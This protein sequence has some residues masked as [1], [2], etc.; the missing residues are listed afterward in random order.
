MAALTQTCKIALP[1]RSAARTTRASRR[2]AIVAKAAAPVDV[3]RVQQ[4]AVAS[5]L[6]VGAVYE[7]M[8][9]PAAQAAMEL[10][11]V[12]EGEPF[13]VNLAWAAIMAT[14]SFSLSLV[15]WGRSGL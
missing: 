2:C 10:T 11:Q 1:A 15:V 7:A 14:F 3:V 9:T 6:T 8:A 13:I 12:A 4:K 5:A